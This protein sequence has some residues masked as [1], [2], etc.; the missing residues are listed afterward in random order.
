V[1]T[2]KTE[3]TLFELDPL[4]VMELHE[5]DAPLLQVLFEKNPEYFWICNGRAP[6]PD[7]ALEEM[8][9]VPPSEMTYSKKYVIGLFNNLSELVGMTIVF[10]NFIA[11][12]VWLISEFIFDKSLHGTGITQQFYQQLE[13][14]MQKNGAEWIRL[15][16]VQGN[17]K[18]ERFWNK[19][20]YIQL[21]E[22]INVPSDMQVNTLRVMAKSLTECSFGEYL[23]LVPRDRQDA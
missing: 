12:H 18:A 11:N 22:R 1:N 6:M 14:W 13:S 8:R 21:R 2:E 16:V 19:V 7:Q 20:G 10:S 9:S 15:G 17:T 4:R 23:L 3:P 5:H